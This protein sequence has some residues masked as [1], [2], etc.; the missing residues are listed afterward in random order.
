MALPRFTSCIRFIKDFVQL[1]FLRF[2]FP[3]KEL[4]ENFQKT[5]KKKERHKH[6]EKASKAKEKKVA[7]DTINVLD[8]LFRE[9]GMGFNVILVDW[10]FISC[11]RRF[12]TVLSWF[13]TWWIY[14]SRRKGNY[15]LYL[16]VDWLI[17]LMFK[18]IVFFEYLFKIF[19]WPG[20]FLLHQ[21]LTCLF[22]FPAFLKA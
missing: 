4:L 9:L 12:A 18:V 7:K 11:K 5:I 1:S 15:C 14:F 13:S 6:N 16:K 8:T 3:E 22:V 2:F 19:D 17:M 21:R 10:H 20:H